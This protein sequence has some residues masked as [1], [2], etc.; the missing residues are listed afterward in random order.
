M[1]APY[2]LPPGPL[3]LPFLPASRATVTVLATRATPAVAPAASRGGKG[4]GKPRKVEAPL[5]VIRAVIPPPAIAAMVYDVGSL[6]LL[7]RV[8]AGTYTDDA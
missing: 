7:F 1:E 6:V 4:K 8:Q 5:Q 3:E 2:A